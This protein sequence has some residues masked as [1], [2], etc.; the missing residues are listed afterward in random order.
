MNHVGLTW[1]KFLQNE[2]RCVNIVQSKPDYLPL[3]IENNAIFK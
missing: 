2:P 3:K 1:S